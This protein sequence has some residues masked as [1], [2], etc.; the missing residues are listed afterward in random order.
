MCLLHLTQSG[1]KDSWYQARQ[2][3]GPP[4]KNAEPTCD[5]VMNMRERH[6]DRIGLAM[7][8]RSMVPHKRCSEE[9]TPFEMKTPEVQLRKGDLAYN[10]SPSREHVSSV[11]DKR[12][13]RAHRVPRLRGCVELGTMGHSAQ[14][15]VERGVS[16]DIR[17]AS[18]LQGQSCQGPVRGV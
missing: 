16:R 5:T 1:A 15:W 13:R 2:V 8:K 11:S 3:F 17:S 14:V 6:V 7:D 12:M 18:R 10:Q 9:H 4:E